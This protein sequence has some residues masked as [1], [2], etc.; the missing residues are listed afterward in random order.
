MRWTTVPILPRNDRMETARDHD[1]AKSDAA[2]RV[3]RVTAG[4]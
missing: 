1:D 4:A 2:A 3:T